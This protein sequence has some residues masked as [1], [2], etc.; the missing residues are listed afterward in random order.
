M[1]SQIQYDLC[2]SYNFINF[3]KNSVTIIVADIPYFVVYNF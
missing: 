2:E 3:L 1:P